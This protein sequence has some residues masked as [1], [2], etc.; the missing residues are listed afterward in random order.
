MALQSTDLFLVNRKVG[1]D[2]KSYKIAYG[3]LKTDLLFETHQ[4]FTD[5]GYKASYVLGVKEFGSQEIAS[6]GYKNITSLR[7]P[8]GSVTAAVLVGDVILMRN[9]TRD[10]QASYGISKITSNVTN[11][12]GTYDEVEVVFRATSALDADLLAPDEL[13]TFSIGEYTSGGDVHVDD[14]SPLNPSEGDLWF[15]S[16]NGIMYVWYLNQGESDGQWVDVRPGGISNGGGGGSAN[17]NEDRG[18]QQFPKGIGLGGA[19]TDIPNL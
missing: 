13:C 3:D 9:T 5:Y 18:I 2:W 6:I 14:E 7:F 1:T 19:W 11:G 16:Y 10:K 4:S 15:N 12:G 17:P 8:A